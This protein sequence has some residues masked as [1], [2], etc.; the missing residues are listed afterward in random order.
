MAVAAVLIAAMLA[1]LAAAGP[2]IGSFSGTGRPATIIVDRGIT[3]SARSRF[4]MLAAS[5]APAVERILGTGPATLC[6]VPDGR[7]IPT[8]LANWANEVGHIDSAASDTRDALRW[9]A[10][11][12]L[13]DPTAIVVLLS[14]RNIGI[15]DR[16]LVQIAPTDR[17]SNVAIAALAVRAQ[18]R[19]QAMVSLLNDSPLRQTVIHIGDVSTKADLPPAG[20]SHNFFVD[21]DSAPASLQAS[22]EPAGDITA[23]SRV[24]VVRRAA[25]PTISPMCAVPAELRRIID[26]YRRNRP[27]GEDSAAVAVVAL[28]SQ[29]PPDRPSAAIMTEG[30]ATVPVTGAVQLQPSPITDGIDWNA[31]M[32]GADTSTISAPPGFQPLV[33]TEGRTLVASSEDLPRQ[34]WIGFR[35]TAWAQTPDFVIFWAKVFDF[36]GGGSGVHYESRTI[37]P[38]ETTLPGLYQRNGQ[39]VAFNAPAVYLDP[40]QTS[41]WQSRLSQLAGEKSVDGE[42]IAPWMIV[43]AMASLLIAAA[44]WSS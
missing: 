4:Q 19:P 14:D 34:V 29:P 30:M 28:D 16:R 10:R 38:M 17:L 2:R 40:A 13:T 1:I 25:W 15:T 31:A 44:R 24:W 8:D 32:R 42:N 26:V 11:R 23:N 21:L 41:D 7:R 6:I 18:P 39:T 9:A 27:A 35:S 20:A 3:M 5:I 37:E 22:I 43:I 33:W 36:L 12:A